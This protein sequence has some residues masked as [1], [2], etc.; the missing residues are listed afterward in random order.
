LT[1]VDGV[2]YIAQTGWIP[3]TDEGFSKTAR[4]VHF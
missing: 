3:G 1:L 2:E 4:I